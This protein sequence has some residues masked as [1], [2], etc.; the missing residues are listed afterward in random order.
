MRARCA[1][2]LRVFIHHLSS[3]HCARHE[4]SR[5]RKHIQTGQGETEQRGG[6]ECTEQYPHA[7]RVIKAAHARLH[8]PT[9]FSFITSDTIHLYAL[10]IYAWKYQELHRK[11]SLSSLGRFLQDRRWHSSTARR[12]R[13]ECRFNSHSTPHPSQKPRGTQQY[14]SPTPW[15]STLSLAI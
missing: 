14:Q 8:L 11:L 3:W 1:C 15:L 9:G 7:F 4:G 12:D 2:H 13:A 10:V 5:D 6:W